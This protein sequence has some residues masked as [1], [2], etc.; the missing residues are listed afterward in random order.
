MRLP[1]ALSEWRRIV[2]QDPIAAYH[3]N[4]MEA[5]LNKHVLPHLDETII[6]LAGSHSSGTKT[7]F[8]KRVNQWNDRNFMESE[9]DKLLDDLIDCMGRV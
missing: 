1:S 9:I 3:A 4:K 2:G 8:V 5:C 7:K 6:E